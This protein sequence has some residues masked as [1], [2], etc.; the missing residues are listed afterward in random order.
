MS[1]GMHSRADKPRYFELPSLAGFCAE[2]VR[3][4][5][6]ERKKEP[7]STPAFA[8]MKSSRALYPLCV[9]LTAW[10]ER[11]RRSSGTRTEPDSAHAGGVPIAVE[12]AAPLPVNQR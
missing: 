12:I 9:L 10:T 3:Y 2:A 5:A 11:P 6:T 8:I 4:Y 1:S 7:K